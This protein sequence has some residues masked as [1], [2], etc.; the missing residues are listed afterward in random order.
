MIA[1]ALRIAGRCVGLYSSPH[2]ERIEERFVV[3][4]TP[5]SAARLVELIDAVRPVAEAMDEQ[6]VGPTFFDLTTAIALRHFAEKRC[7]TVVLEVGLGGRL[8]STNVVTPA[9]AVVTSISLDHTTQLGETLS[10]IATE[11]AGIFKPGVPAVIGVA[12][13]EA[14]DTLDRIARERNCPTLRR[15]EHFDIHPVGPSWRFTRGEE[16]IAGVSPR[17]PGA[18]FADNAATALATLG[19]VHDLEGNVPIDARRRGVN[20]ARLAARMERFE[21][22]PLVV[23]DGAHNDA[24]AEALADALDELCGG[25]PIARRV[26]LVAISQE[27]DARAILGPLAGHFG[28]VVATRYVDNPRAEPPER[29]ASLREGAIA[30]ENPIKGFREAQKLA[31]DGG[32]VVVAGSLFLAAEIRRVVV[33]DRAGR[34]TAQQNSPG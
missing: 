15:G 27:K 8:D 33:A 9:V 31:G 26:L 16:S 10:E 30:Y 6:G 25:I 13:G 7:D 12:N 5:C 22:S 19:V 32:A 20:R 3:D 1:E 34:T 18:A 2:L 17:S 4:G 28:A 11:K 24:S 29:L 23:I 21:G 14:G